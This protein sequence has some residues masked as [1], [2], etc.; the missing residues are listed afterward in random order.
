MKLSKKTLSKRFDLLEEYN[1]RQD[2]TNRDESIE[3]KRCFT[4]QF[5]QTII[6]STAIMAAVISIMGK[7]PDWLF[8]AIT[9]ALFPAS[10]V[11]V[12]LV[13]GFIPGLLSIQLSPH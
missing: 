12:N 10:P 1:F 7:E 6:A 8:L 11:T 5:H 4:T 2:K 13:G 3:V 9:S